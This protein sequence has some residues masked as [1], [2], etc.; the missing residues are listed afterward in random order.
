MKYTKLR[1]LEVSQIGLGC[2][3][4][5]HS[6]TPFPDR[7]EMIKLMRT[8]HDMGVTFYDTAEIYGPHTNEE[9]VGEGLKPIRDKVVL[10]TKCGIFLDENGNQALDSKPATIRKSV[11]GSLKRLKTDYIDLYYLHRVDPNT[12]IEES[13]QTMKE[14]YQ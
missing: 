2:M 14:L 9:L 7:N 5:T 13:A 1:D 12:P 6:Y 10:A 8:A 11:E 3:G 4:M